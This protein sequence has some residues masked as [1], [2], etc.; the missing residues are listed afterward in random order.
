LLCF[1]R[2]F[3]FLALTEILV[4]RL[5]LVPSGVGP[6]FTNAAREDNG[7]EKKEEEQSGNGDRELCNHR[8]R[9]VRDWNSHLALNRPVDQDFINN[10][11]GTSLTL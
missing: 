2:H 5:V 8:D 7:D 11:L 10:F 6:V 3:K 1:S 4:D 9:R